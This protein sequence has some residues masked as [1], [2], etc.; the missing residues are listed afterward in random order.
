MT[1]KKN[2]V[3][4]WFMNDWGKHGSAY[5]EIALALAKNP[6]IGKVTCILPPVKAHEPRLMANIHRFARNLTVITPLLQSANKSGIGWRLRA[7]FNHRCSPPARLRL[8]LR[9]NGYRKEHTVLWVYPPHQFI[10][11]LINNIPHKTLV[12]QIVDNNSFK[13]DE[14]QDMEFSKAQYNELAQSADLVITSSK[15]SQSIFSRLNNNCLFVEHG[16]SERFIC[17]PSDFPFI[18][19]NLQPRLGYLG[20]ISQ[21]ADIE[22]IR[23]VALSRPNYL[24]LIAGSDEGMLELSGIT[25]LSNVKCIGPIPYGR[26]PSFLKNLD[27]CLM[28]HKDNDDSRSINLLKMFQYLASGRPI[29]STKVAGIEK[30]K[31]LVMLSASYDAFV[32]NIDTTFE[33]DNLEKSAIRI[34]AAKAENWANRVDCMMNKLMELG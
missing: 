32:H 34:N 25:K 13:A 2:I 22:L 9:L 15:S 33:T 27:I 31:D 6:N 18:K 1:A 26:A 5:E 30:W 4:F 28:P 8:Y 14:S 19:N 16:V 21:H 23:H 3:L 7:W 12:T 10:P 17:A 11:E 20:W 29:V 24:L